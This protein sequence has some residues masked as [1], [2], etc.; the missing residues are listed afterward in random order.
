MN[1]PFLPQPKPSKHIRIKPKLKDRCNFSPGVRK[2]IKVRDN[3][4]C[5]ECESNFGDSIHHVVPRG[6]DGRGKG[7]YTNGLLVCFSCHTKI[8]NDP[9][10]LQK[11]QE[12]FEQRYGPEHWKDEWD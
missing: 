7:V 5:Q 3:G 8:H 12:I 2:E 6:R 9:K 11:W 1:L 4:I 10:L